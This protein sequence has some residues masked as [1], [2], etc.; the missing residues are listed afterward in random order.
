[1]SRNTVFTAAF[2]I[3]ALTS[4]GC[5]IC[6]FWLLATGA[7]STAVGGLVLSSLMTMIAA[8]VMTWAALPNDLPFSRDLEMS[9]VP[10]SLDPHMP[11]PL[12]RDQ[13][14]ERFWKSIEDGNTDPKVPII[15]EMLRYSWNASWDRKFN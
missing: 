12:L 5:S 7:S 9:W 8:F 10:H 3:A 11:H 1:M 13:E 6:L 15:K 2:W 4:A 14:F